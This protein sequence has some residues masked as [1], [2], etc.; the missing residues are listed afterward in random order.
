[1]NLARAFQFVW[2]WALLACALYIIFF[3]TQWENTLTLAAEKKIDLGVA[4]FYRYRDADIATDGSFGNPTFA[5]LGA[6]LRFTGTRLFWSAIVLLT[7][8][9]SYRRTYGF[10][11]LLLGLIVCGLV[12][13]EAFLIW[14]LLFAALVSLLQRFA[15]PRTRISLALA[16]A[17]FILFIFS[18]QLAWIMANPARVLKRYQVLGGKSHWDMLQ[19]RALPKIDLRESCL[20]AIN[21]DDLRGVQSVELLSRRSL[22]SLQEIVLVD[23]KV[24]ESN[25][26]FFNLKNEAGDFIFSDAARIFAEKEKSYA[27][28]VRMRLESVEK[29]CLMA[30]FSTL[31]ELEKP[32]HSRAREIVDARR[33]RGLTTKIIA[34]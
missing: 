29:L 5:I 9:L 26:G 22:A 21:P 28:S 10:R 13:G 19:W 18:V 30:P 32:P 24:I 12:W 14:G 4:L 33:K 16:S 25:Y 6:L 11:L 8:L 27:T 2:L 34:I 3:G 20:A 31:P 1:M 15:L 17:S 23:L 7:G